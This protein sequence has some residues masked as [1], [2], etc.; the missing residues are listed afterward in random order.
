MLAILLALLKTGELVYPL[1]PRNCSAPP[2]SSCVPTAFYTSFDLLYS[3]EPCTAPCCQ[4]LLPRLIAGC[5]LPTFMC[6]YRLPMDSAELAVMEFGRVAVISKEAQGTSCVP[7][8][9]C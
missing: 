2:A 4:Q 6:T 7:Q 1:L 8:T 9:V 5:L 3:G